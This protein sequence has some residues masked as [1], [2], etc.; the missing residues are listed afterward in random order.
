MSVPFPLASDSSLSL[1]SLSPFSLSPSL[2]GACMRMLLYLFSSMFSVLYARRDG[3]CSD[4]RMPRHGPD[5]SGLRMPLFVL[6]L[7]LYKRAR[8]HTHTHTRMHTHTHAYIHAHMHAHAH[9]HTH[10]QTHTR[11]YAYTHSRTHTRTHTHTHTRTHEEERRE[12]EN[13]KE[14][15]GCAETSLRFT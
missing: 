14:Q 6:A 13:K 9:A 10:T 4:W 7:T 1:P 12:E 5:G 8:K 11:T 3:A 15:A 2:L